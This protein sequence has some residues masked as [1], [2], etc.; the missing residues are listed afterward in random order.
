[1]AT[2]SENKAVASLG[3][4]V[5]ASKLATNFWHFSSFTSP[6]LLCQASQKKKEKKKK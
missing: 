3:V 6:Y 2:Q 5:Q 1:M 4:I